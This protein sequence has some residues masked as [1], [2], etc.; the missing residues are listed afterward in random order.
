MGLLTAWKEFLVT[1]DTT[2]VLA[3]DQILGDKGHG[4]YRVYARAAAAADATITIND[5][6]TNVVDAAPIPVRAAAVTYP[7]IKKNE[8]HSWVV[9]YKGR[10]STLPINIADG[11]N[12]E[13]AL[14]VEYLGP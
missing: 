10:G 4:K 2:G 1:A 8:D 3:N 12:A 5:G 13:V 7:E 9:H 6:D 14:L 11:T